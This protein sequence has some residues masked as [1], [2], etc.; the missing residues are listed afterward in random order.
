MVLKN[1][2]SDVEHGVL[3]V[4]KVSVTGFLTIEILSTKK[5]FKLTDQL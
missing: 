5:Y 2:I 1:I 3:A 4:R